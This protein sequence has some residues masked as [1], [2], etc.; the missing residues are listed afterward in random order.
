MYLNNHHIYATYHV[1]RKSKFMSKEDI[2][3]AHPFTYHVIIFEGDIYAYR[4]MMS[5][6]KEKK[7]VEMNVILTD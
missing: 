6:N 5:F 7:A 3:N 2:L 1:H 4:I